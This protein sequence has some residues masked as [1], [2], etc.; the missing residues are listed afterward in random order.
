MLG[1][2]G[3]DLAERGGGPSWYGRHAY[4]T[5]A[6]AAG[7]D[8]SHAPA[9]LRLVRVSTATP[10]PLGERRS[11]LRPRAGRARM[12]GAAAPELKFI[13]TLNDSEEVD[14]FFHVLLEDEGCRVTIVQT[15]IK[16]VAAIR[17]VSFDPLVR[18]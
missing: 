15:Q 9:P 12:Q 5:V 8:P 13:L 2:F 17:A 10:P 14:R 16:D 3:G 6:R 4:R 7:S 11:A 18:D 1:K